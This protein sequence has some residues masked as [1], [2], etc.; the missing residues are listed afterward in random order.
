V[1]LVLH[2]DTEALGVLVSTDLHDW[3]GLA[4]HRGE[5]A[6]RSGLVFLGAAGAG[7]GTP[8]LV[9]RI[10]REGRAEAVVADEEALPAAERRC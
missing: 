4:G 9:R 1:V 5:F 7:E 10:M 2:D 3:D 8:D 6:L